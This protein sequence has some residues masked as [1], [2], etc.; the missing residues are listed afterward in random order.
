[1]REAETAPAQGLFLTHKSTFCK[2]VKTVLFLIGCT[3]ALDDLVNR[4]Y[5][6]MGKWC[7]GRPYGAKHKLD[8]PSFIPLDQDPLCNA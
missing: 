4:R 5:F 2:L 8:L 6:A 1:M 3:L 7:W